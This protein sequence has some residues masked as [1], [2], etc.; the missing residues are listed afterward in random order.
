MI[1]GLI[2]EQVSKNCW[3]IDPNM[4]VEDKQPLKIARYNIPLALFNNR[5]IFAVGGMVTKTKGTD[6][7][8][9]YDIK[10]NNWYNGPS[11]NKPRA[12]TSTCIMN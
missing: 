10:T 2:G 7:V 1:G 11:V 6:S 12:F 5:Y 9:V 3:E 8:E 4:I